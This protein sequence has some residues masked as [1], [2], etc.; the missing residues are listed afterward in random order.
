MT[1][2]SIKMFLTEADKRA[3]RAL[4]YSDEAIGRMKPDEGARLIREKGEKLYWICE[5]CVRVIHE[6]YERTCPHC[7]TAKPATATLMTREEADSRANQPQVSTTTEP[8]NLFLEIIQG[9]GNIGQKLPIKEGCCVVGS[10]RGSETNNTFDLS[11][12]DFSGRISSAHIKIDCHAGAIWAMDLGSKNGTIINNELIE[13][14]KEIQLK[15]GD[16]IRI[17][18][19]VFKVSKN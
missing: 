11:H 8:S 13:S 9:P 10:Q 18:N 2:K 1:G 5:H 15:V 4:G 17:G 7:Q 19:I 16:K 12:M 6:E 3:L 14:G